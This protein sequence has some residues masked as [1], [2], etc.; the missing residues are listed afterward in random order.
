MKN[1]MKDFE[2]AKAE[3][4][5]KKV[6]ELWDRTYQAWMMSNEHPDSIGPTVDS[7]AALSVWESIQD[8]FEKIPKSEK[9]NLPIFPFATIQK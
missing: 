3:H 1:L 5:E 6:V 8:S 4:L 7:Q 9:P 2:P